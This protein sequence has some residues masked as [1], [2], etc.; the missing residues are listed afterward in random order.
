MKLEPETRDAFMA[1][2]KR[3]GRPASQLVREF[4]RDSVQH[5]RDYVEFLPRKV[6][7]SRR[8]IAEG[9]WSSHEDG[10]ARAAARRVELQRRVDEI[11]S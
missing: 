4:M 2:A 9:R 3:Q 1:V 5:D 6:E 8:S 11:D 7:K 10:E